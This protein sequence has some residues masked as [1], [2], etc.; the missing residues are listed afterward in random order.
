MRRVYVYSEF[1]DSNRKFGIA[2]LGNIFLI[3]IEGKNVLLFCRCK[4]PE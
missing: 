2:K 1:M 4:I 3:V